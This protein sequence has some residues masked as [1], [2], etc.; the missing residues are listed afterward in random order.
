[1]STPES[2]CLEK[3]IRL[4]SKTSYSKR[5]LSDK[6]SAAY[7]PLL[8]EKCIRELVHLGYLK[9]REECQIWLNHYLLSKKSKREIYYSL[10]KRGY[11][12]DLI[13]ELL[14]TI[15]AEREIENAL[16][17]V[18]NTKA[19]VGNNDKAKEKLF[20]KLLRKGFSAE[21]VRI[22]LKTYTNCE[23]ESDF[24]ENTDSLS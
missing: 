20:A 16:L 21:I 13:S 7:D 8:V 10:L 17:L 24:Y 6:L 15:T 3:A 2:E 23:F 4:L 11:E 18:K 22:A 12:K 5:R 9:E 14:N 1:M 19:T